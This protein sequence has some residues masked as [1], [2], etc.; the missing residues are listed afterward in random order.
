MITCH[1]AGDEPLTTIG[2]SRRIVNRGGT[3]TSAAVTIGL[4]IPIGSY[5]SEL[6]CSF[7]N[8]AGSSSYTCFLRGEYSANCAICEY[9]TINFSEPI[10]SPPV[11]TGVEQTITGTFFI[12]WDHTLDLHLLSRYIVYIQAPDNSTVRVST[13]HPRLEIPNKEFNL[14]ANENIVV[15]AF[16]QI[17]ESNA[18]TIFLPA[19]SNEG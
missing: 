5:P 19:I 17:T 4:S 11:I 14:V 18:R 8:N 13:T 15:A 2:M 12:Q 7:S 10:L 9:K 3:T 1:V 6:N 16:T